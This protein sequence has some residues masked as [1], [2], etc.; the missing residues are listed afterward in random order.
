E[1]RIFRSDGPG[2]WRWPAGTRVDIPRGTQPAFQ[3]VAVLPGGAFR[4]TGA[5]LTFGDRA[6]GALVAGTSLDANYAQELSNLSTAGV[7]ITVNSA[8]VA[9]AGPEQVARGP[10]A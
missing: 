8:V 4:V 1:G 7:V 6:I 9:R 2:S 5:R 3:S 10:V